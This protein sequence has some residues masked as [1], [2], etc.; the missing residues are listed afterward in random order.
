MIKIAILIVIILLVLLFQYS[1]EGLE[2][3]NVNY[4][5]LQGFKTLYQQPSSSAAFVSEA[6]KVI[7]DHRNFMLLSLIGFADAHFVRCFNLLI[8]YCIMRFH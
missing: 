8:Y 4:L 2:N 6:N 5:Y 1:K 7:S 3:C